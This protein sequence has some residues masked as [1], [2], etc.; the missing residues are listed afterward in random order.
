M[1]QS[2]SA[3]IL[4]KENISDDRG[5]LRT[6]GP[7]KNMTVLDMLKRKNN[8]LGAIE[9]VRP[10]PTIKFKKVEEFSSIGNSKLPPLAPTPKA[11]LKK[12]PQ[13]SVS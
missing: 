3:D 4:P 7:P 5:Y 13:F 9:G 1:A 8:S 11:Q 2:K 10:L 6:P 12:K